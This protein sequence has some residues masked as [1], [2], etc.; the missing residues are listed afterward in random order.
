MRYLYFKLLKIAMESEQKIFRLLGKVQHYDW[1][2]YEFIP[3]SLGIS[4]TSHKPFA[5]YWLGTH[6]KS[7]SE[8]FTGDE[9]KTL[10]EFTELP[11]LLKLQ[12]VREM[13]SIQ[14]HPTKKA[15]EIEF[16]RE[17]HEHIPLDAPNRNY[18]D[19]NHKPELLVALGE[20]WLLHGFKKKESILKI[21]NA[22]PEFSSL[23]QMFDLKGYEELY[24]TVM[25]MPQEAVNGILQPVLGRVA[26]L[27]SKGVLNKDEEDYWAAKAALSFNTAG[28]IDRGIFSIYFFNLVQ[29]KKGEG[30]YQ[31]PGMP[32]AYLEGRGVEIMANSD[33]VL[34]GGLT[35]K[36]I[37]IKELMKHVQCE[38]VIP[39]I[40]KGIKRNKE[41]VFKTPAPD[42][43][44]S[45]FQLE[46]NEIA[47]FTP[48]SI[49]IIF[50]FTGNAEFKDGNSVLRLK[51][52]QA[53]VIFPG[54]NVS[55]KALPEAEIYRASAPMHS[56]E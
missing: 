34:R 46:E 1:G 52:G 10:S 55:I 31:S 35:T 47:E 9:I 30:I 6:H 15:A 18:R 19:D 22:V 38:P 8:I 41:L 16:A 36:H 25:G 3:A 11:Y 40:I 50:L 49:E 7:P 45:T 26:P 4:N 48:A 23:K 5:E 51:K 33:N 42:F 24:K 43:E 56:G 29:L 37:D 28:N 53:A 27:Y 12:D 14:V 17:S 2:G 13:L 44:L 21:L 20:F 32:H 54:Q 39:Q